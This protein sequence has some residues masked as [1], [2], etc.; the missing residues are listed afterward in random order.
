MTPGLGRTV[1]E[2]LSPVFAWRIPWIEPGGLEPMASLKET[3]RNTHAHTHQSLNA[4]AFNLGIQYLD[5]YPEKHTDTKTNV[6]RF[7]HV[8]ISIKVSARNNTVNQT[9]LQ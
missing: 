2:E 3:R 7:S 8:Y 9:M 4:H 6:Q 1:E 5:M